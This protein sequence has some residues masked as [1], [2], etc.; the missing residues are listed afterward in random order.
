MRMMGGTWLQLLR[1]QQLHRLLTGLHDACSGTREVWGSDRAGGPSSPAEG[2]GGS[3]APVQAGLRCP[4]A[5]AAAAQICQLPLQGPLHPHPHWT[6]PLPCS[7]QCLLL[8]HLR[9]LDAKV[10]L[11]SSRTVD[12]ICHMVGCFVQAV[13][14]ALSIHTLCIRASLN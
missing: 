2:Q 14:A 1:A 12:A 6:Y 10:V 9:L 3:S 8:P 11:H 13:H 5:A 7:G 4:A